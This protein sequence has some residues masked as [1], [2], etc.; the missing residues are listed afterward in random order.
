M[1][2]QITVNKSYFHKT[3]IT[4]KWSISNATVGSDL[5]PCALK[6]DVLT[7]QLKVWTATQV[8]SGLLHSNRQTLHPKVIQT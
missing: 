3:T 7:T 1:V 8:A 2:Q 4:L 5:Q 6:V